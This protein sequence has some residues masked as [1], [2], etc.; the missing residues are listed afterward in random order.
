ME[1]V[2]E[3][4]EETFLEVYQEVKYALANVNLADTTTEVCNA[5]IT[6]LKKISGFDKI[7]VYQFDEDWNGTV[8]AEIMEDGMESYLG[9]R[10]PASDIPKPARELYLKNPYRLIPNVDFTPVKLVPVINPVTQTFIDLSNCNLR[11]VPAVHIE[12]LKNMNVM[13]SMSTAVIKDNKLWGLISCHHRT[14]KYLS[15]EK[16]SL[17]ELMSGVISARLSTIHHKEEAFRNTQRQ[18]VQAELIK[19]VYADESLISGLSSYA[20]NILSLLQSEGA[21]IIY[22]KKM[23]T[24]GK[25]PGKSEIKGLVL[26]LQNNAESKA[27]SLHNLSS[28][29][30]EA[31]TYSD[32][33]SGV[34]VLPIH[35]EKGEYIIGFRPELIEKVNWG[36]N[37]NEAIKFEKDNIKYHPGILSGCGRKQ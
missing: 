2:N 6:E 37:P 15:Y 14:P 24:I 33:A 36:G 34:I 29:F 26:W 1:Q 5:A 11:S 20:V 4:E 30:E 3:G 23:E 17:F 27:F 21:V 25:T 7:M 32:V 16:C 19:Q 12:Y 10:F 28:Y 13:A 31:R 8:I 18:S 35:H 22:N 9:L